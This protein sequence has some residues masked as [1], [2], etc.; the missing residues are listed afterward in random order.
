M[1]ETKELK[2]ENRK[3]KK[4]LRSLSDM[5]LLYLHGIDDLFMEEK[6]ISPEISRKLGLLSNKLDYR[7][8]QIRHFILNLGISAKD[9][10]R[11]VKNIKKARNRRSI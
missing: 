2:R 11:A 8:D 3:L 5:I 6:S 9:K 10:E 7:N 1:N 4:E